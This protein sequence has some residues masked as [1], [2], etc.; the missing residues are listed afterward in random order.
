MERIPQILAKELGRPLKHIEN[1]ISL[2]DEGNTIPF[3]ARYRK[4]MHGT[5][6]DTAL[7]T[8]EERLTYLRNLAERRSSITKSIEEQGK[9]TDELKA[10]LEAAATLAELED[11]YRPYKPKRRTRATIAKEKGLEP[12]ALALFEQRRDL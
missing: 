5:M 1:V 8:L 9:L 10:K 11:L 2:L 3:I 4:E 6:D 7:R 12:L